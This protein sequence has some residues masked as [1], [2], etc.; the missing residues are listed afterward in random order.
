MSERR[1]LKPKEL[2]TVYVC[3]TL[4]QTKIKGILKE[5]EEV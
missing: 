1:Q 4:L 5:V 3:C 2:T